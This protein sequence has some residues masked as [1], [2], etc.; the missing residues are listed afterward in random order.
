MK[1]LRETVVRLKPDRP[2]SVEINRIDQNKRGIGIQASRPEHILDFSVRPLGNP[3][4]Y[5]ATRG[6]DFVSEKLARL[7]SA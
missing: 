7:I 6:V 4:V 5:F 2:C 1:R 3:V